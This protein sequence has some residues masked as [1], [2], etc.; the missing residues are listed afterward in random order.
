MSKKKKWFKKGLIGSV[1]ILLSASIVPSSLVFA[2][3]VDSN[4]LDKT[5]QETPVRNEPNAK[6]EDP[7]TEVVEERSEN[8]I[9]LDNRDGSF[10]KQVYQEP[11]HIENQETGELE[12]IETELVTDD[13]EKIIEPKN[14]EL[15]AQF[16]LQME[17][18]LYQEVG[19]G[20]TA[21]RFS[22][23]GSTSFGEANTSGEEQTTEV[24]T[25]DPITSKIESEDTK[26][27]DPD[28]EQPMHGEVPAIKAEDRTAEVKDNVALYSDVL[29]SV[30][31]RQTVFN[32]SVKEDLIV[33]APMALQSIYF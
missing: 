33:K 16:L 24:S 7:P 31:F 19:E 30:D 17:Q 27:E 8:E 2:E 32:R 28:P 22:L 10:T 1:A 25:N 21:I 13:T 11:I 20:D 4:S 23:Q 14:T 5:V 15:Q 3:T 9:V 26:S 29:P 18:G 12:R 6:Q